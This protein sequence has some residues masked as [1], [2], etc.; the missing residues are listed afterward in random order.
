[1][2]NKIK[3]YIQ[4]DRNYKTGDIIQLGWKID[5]G[6]NERVQYFKGLL[7]KKNSGI[8]KTI[9]IRGIVQGVGVECVIPL[10][11]PKIFSV[12]VKGSSPIKR[13]KLYFT[14][15]IPDKISSLS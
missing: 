14:R 1:M 7:I 10:Y 4:P 2:L 6:R 9:T 5:E 8:F 13:S 15:N 3:E 11:S 12:D